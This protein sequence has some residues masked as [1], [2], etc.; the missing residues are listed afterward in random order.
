MTATTETL[1]SEPL[2][3]GNI[4]HYRVVDGTHYT[5]GM[6]MADGTVDRRATPQE[7]IALLE[8]L[9]RDRTPVRI[10]Y[11]GEDGQSWLC[12]DDVIGRI[13]RSTGR[14]KIPLLVPLRGDGGPGLLDACI[15]R[16]DRR[17]GVLW[18][19][20]NFH[21]PSMAVTKGEVERVP[22]EVHVAGGVHARFPSTAEAL[23]WVDFIRGNVRFPDRRKFAGAYS[24]DRQ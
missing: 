12:E 13:G 8:T 22:W 18:K 2:S 7:V 24:E 1:V 23:A 17:A 9:R 14:I 16:I 11:G 10:Y 4:K 5:A 19:H 21:V 3:N 6:T 20:P 15:V